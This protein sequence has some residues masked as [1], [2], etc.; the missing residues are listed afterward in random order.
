MCSYGEA[1]RTGPYNRNIRRRMT[2]GACSSVNLKCAVTLSVA[3]AFQCLL[4]QGQFNIT[5]TVI[6]RYSFSYICGMAIL[7]LRGCEDV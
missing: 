4:R 2:Q 5:Q 6:G 3:C 7:L 1:V